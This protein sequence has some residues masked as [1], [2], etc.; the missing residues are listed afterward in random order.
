MSIRYGRSDCNHSWRIRAD[1]DECQCTAIICIECGA[2]GCGCDIK[3]AHEKQNLYVLAEYN[4]DA[5]INGLWDNPRCS[6]F[7]WGEDE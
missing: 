3:T 2:Y 5:N 6:D 1:G 4:G 7:K